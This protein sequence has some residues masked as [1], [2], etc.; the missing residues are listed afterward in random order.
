MKIGVLIIGSVALVAMAACSPVSEAG[1]GGFGAGEPN[2]GRP[3][4]VANASDPLAGT[5]WALV[6]NSAIMLSFAGGTI[7]GNSGCNGFSG[8]YRLGSGG[9]FEVSGLIATLRACIEPL[10]ADER[11]FLAQLQAADRFT[12]ANGELTLY[13]SNGGPVPLRF[14]VAPDG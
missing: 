9:G 12:L 10:M 1:S 6:D 13:Q 11:A 8:Q 14:R 4:A 7:S 3:D 5:A 2:D